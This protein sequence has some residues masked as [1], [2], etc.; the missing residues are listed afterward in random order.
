M[1]EATTKPTRPCPSCGKANDATFVMCTSCYVLM[2]TVPAPTIQLVP[3]PAC[4]NS[5][6]P[7]AT[8]CPKC[9]HPFGH[10]ESPQ[11]N[12]GGL[13]GGFARPGAEIPQP[14]R[15]LDDYRKPYRH[16]TSGM[17][18]AFGIVTVLGIG[19]FLVLL[20]SFGSS[21]ESGRSGQ[22]NTGPVADSFGLSRGPYGIRITN[23]TA[24]PAGRP[25]VRV[26]DRWEGRTA[27][28]IDG[29]S[30]AVMPYTL[31][32]DDS[33]RRFNIAEYGIK[34]I[35]VKAEGAT[36]WQRFSADWK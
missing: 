1:S 17:T 23:E 26:N 36:V 8:A 21:G 20:L 35:W 34:E 30:M 22:I 25:L 10:A 19:L 6:S 24:H 28:P 13:P 3:C 15:D 2:D 11:I 16:K 18:V 12:R 27:V 29:G 14:G 9:G 5:V 31:L 32:F 33:Q 4:S 7:K